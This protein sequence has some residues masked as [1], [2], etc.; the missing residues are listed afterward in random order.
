MA[1][2]EDRSAAIRGA[3]EH[4]TFREPLTNNRAAKMWTRD[5]MVRR[6][7]EQ[8]EIAKQTS[9]VAKEMEFGREYSTAELRAMGAH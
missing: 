1:S 4:L 8:R 2:K 9:K 5:E 7:V 6:A 3:Y